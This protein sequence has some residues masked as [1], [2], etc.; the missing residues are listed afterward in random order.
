MDCLLDLVV[1]HKAYCRGNICELGM[2]EHILCRLI[3]S[4]SVFDK[5]IRSLLL[6]ERSPQ[7]LG[8]MRQAN[9]QIS[10]LVKSIIQDCSERPDEFRDIEFISYLT[11]KYSLFK[12]LYQEISNL[13]SSLNHVQQSTSPQSE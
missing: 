10:L 5:E 12:R 6:R 4:I 9:D 3:E 8:L 11:S 7:L 1:R 2:N 13:K